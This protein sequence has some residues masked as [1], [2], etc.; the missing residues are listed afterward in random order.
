MDSERWA[1]RKQECQADLEK[2][3]FVVEVDQEQ[4]VGVPEVDLQEKVDLEEEKRDS[5]ETGVQDLE[6]ATVKQEAGEASDWLEGGSVRAAKELVV[7]AAT[8][9]AFLGTE[10]AEEV[11]LGKEAVGLVELVGLVEAECLLEEA[12]SEAVDLVGYSG[13]FVEVEAAEAWLDSAEG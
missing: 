5:D 1:A 6:E 9:Q 11:A 10:V 3:G 13:D 4:A 8:A 7:A 12:G 2:A